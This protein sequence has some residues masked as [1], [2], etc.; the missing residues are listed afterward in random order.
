MSSRQRPVAQQCKRKSVETPRGL[1]D[2]G[3]GLDALEAGRAL[4]AEH[5]LPGRSALPFE[6]VMLICTKC[7]AS[8]CQVG[9]LTAHLQKRSKV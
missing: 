5:H 6:M 2:P 8:L 4:L 9:H 1:Q 3:A 7:A